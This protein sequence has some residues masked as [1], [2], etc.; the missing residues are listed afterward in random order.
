MTGTKTR[1]LTVSFFVMCSAAILV[2]PGCAGSSSI[3]VQIITASI[4]PER[5]T[6]NDRIIVRMLARD[7]MSLADNAIYSQVVVFDCDDEA[8]RYPAFPRLGD[9]PMDNFAAMRSA[10]RMRGREDVVEVQGDVL[11]SFVGRVVR[12]CVKMEG[13]GYLGGRLRSNV[14]AV[15]RPGLR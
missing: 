2:S 14:A 10:L 5:S 1:C 12:I 7:V 8:V 11:R 13:G 9:T 6:S 15:S 4:A 3:H